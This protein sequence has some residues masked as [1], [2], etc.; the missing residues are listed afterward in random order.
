MGQ[1]QAHVP[2]PSPYLHLG[3]AAISEHGCTA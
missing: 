1:D 2:W 3:P